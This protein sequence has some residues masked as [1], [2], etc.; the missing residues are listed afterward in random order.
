M[1][2]T[3]RPLNVSSTLHWRIHYTRLPRET[4]IGGYRGRTVKK[5]QQTKQK[6][7]RTKKKKKKEKSGKSKECAL[8][9]R[10]QIIPL[11]TLF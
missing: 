1:T 5:K 2:F 9:N 4:S 7:E 11:Y 6:R 10:A 8:S 3:N